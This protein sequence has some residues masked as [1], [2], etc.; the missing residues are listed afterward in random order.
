[1]SRMLP[2]YLSGET[3]IPGVIELQST[4]SYYSDKV[5]YIVCKWELLYAFPCD[6]I[7]FSKKKILKGKRS[8]GKMKST[9]ITGHHITRNVAVYGPMRQYCR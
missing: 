5:W 6:Y 1:M 7:L 4:A 9:D 8:K 3:P 2:G